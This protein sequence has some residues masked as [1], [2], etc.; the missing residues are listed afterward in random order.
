MGKP[1]S[2]AKPKERC[3]E[4]MHAHVG[5]S[6]GD[7]GWLVTREWEV[8]LTFATLINHQIHHLVQWD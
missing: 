8:S 7:S 3:L 5:Y 2:L 1:M 6:L 4:K